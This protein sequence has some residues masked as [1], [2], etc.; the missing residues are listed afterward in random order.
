MQN[1][2]SIN[3]NDGGVAQDVNNTYL[4]RS[5]G[6]LIPYSIWYYSIIPSIIVLFFIGICIYLLIA[7]NIK[8]RLMRNPGFNA[9]YNEI[10][11]WIIR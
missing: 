1:K 6:T 11:Y 7:I 9:S 10:T 5:F 8:I 2:I 3:T 4:S